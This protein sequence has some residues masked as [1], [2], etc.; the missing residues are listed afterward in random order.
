[1]SGSNFGIDPEAAIAQALSGATSDSSGFGGT[2][3]TGIDYQRL[4]QLLGTVGSK[5]SA[6]SNDANFDKRGGEGPGPF[7]GGGQGL[8]NLLA[9]LIQ[10]HRQ[11]MLVRPT[12][13]LQPR[14]SLLG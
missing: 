6:A 11:A 2:G 8:S 14:M 5:A 13:P 7:S 10:M 4:A 1:M 9:T 12:E 3:G